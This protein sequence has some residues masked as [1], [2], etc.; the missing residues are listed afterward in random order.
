MATG[1]G[2]SGCFQKVGM[3]ITKVPMGFCHTNFRDTHHLRDLFHHLDGFT[4]TKLVAPLWW[5]VTGDRS[6][7]FNQIHPA[8][9]CNLLPCENFQKVWMFKC[10]EVRLEWAVA[11]AWC[12][13]CPL[14][15]GFRLLDQSIRTG[16]VAGISLD[17]VVSQL[18]EQ[19]G[20]SKSISFRD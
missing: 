15:R 14:W 16:D 1:R 10:F 3:V 5:S 2:A 13:S 4:T 6:F 9:L 8:S 11:L 12:L 20:L 17:E 19:W 18:W 7:K